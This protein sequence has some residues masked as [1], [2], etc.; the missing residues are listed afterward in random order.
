MRA[1][2]VYGVDCRGRC[3]IRI[4]KRWTD[5]RSNY[6]IVAVARDRSRIAVSNPEG[7]HALFSGAQ[8]CLHRVPKALPETDGH[9]HIVRSQD[10][11]F[12]LYCPGAS[13]RR[14]SV[15]PK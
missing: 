14:L 10:L 4:K 8:H 3:N 12:M 6:V 11:Y 15:E 9:E 13:R 7:R 1:S 2:D 5:Y